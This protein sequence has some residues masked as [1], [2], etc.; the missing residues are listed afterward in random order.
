M[1]LGETL[2]V[3]VASAT[4]AAYSYIQDTDR[5]W[6][7]RL[8]MSV[9]SFILAAITASPVASVVGRDPALVAI[10]VGAFGVV[11]GEFAQALLADR[12]FIRGLIMAI[13]GR[14]K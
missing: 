5:T 14:G 6:G 3:W 9:V 2:R 8:A 12:T 11:A 13:V 10:A 7:P 4:G 1:L